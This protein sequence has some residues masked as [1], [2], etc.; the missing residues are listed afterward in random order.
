MYMGP[1]ELELSAPD[2]HVWVDDKGQ[3]I[4]EWNFGIFKSPKKPTKSWEINWPLT[5][6]INKVQGLSNVQS[7]NL[8]L[9]AL[10]TP[11]IILNFP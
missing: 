4:S 7:N 2:A 10:Q 6:N 3:L 1:I 11:S 5:Y 8:I 9:T